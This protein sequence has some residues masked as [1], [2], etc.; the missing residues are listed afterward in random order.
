MKL[1]INDKRDLALSASSRLERLLSQYSYMSR[2]LSQHHYL[3]SPANIDFSSATL[4]AMDVGW[5]TG[6]WTISLRGRLD[7]I[8]QS[9]R[10]YLFVVCPLNF[11]AGH[12]IHY[13]YSSN[14]LLEITSYS[15]FWQNIAPRLET[16]RAAKL[17]VVS[18][19]RTEKTMHLDLLPLL[20]PRQ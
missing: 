5:K 6:F 8:S 11:E 12:I 3:L 19:L 9:V 17:E 10:P 14:S 18:N 2:V 7:L 1:L 20:L 4:E 13:Q 16:E 15:C